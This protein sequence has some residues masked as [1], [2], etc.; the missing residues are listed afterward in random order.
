[1][2]EKPFTSE[3]SGFLQL[4]WLFE[5]VRCAGHDLERF[6]TAQQAVGFFVELD[7]AVVE[8]AHNKKRRRFDLGEIPEREVRAAPARNHRAHFGSW[9]AA[10]KAAAAPVLAPK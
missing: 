9:A 4:A 10:I 6:L 8:S 1:M 5:Q 2:A 3:A 7:Y